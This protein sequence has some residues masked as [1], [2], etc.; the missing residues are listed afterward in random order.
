MSPD[1]PAGSSW[2]ARANLAVLTELAKL[3]PLP[4]DKH[5]LARRLWRLDEW[6]SRR[7]DRKDRNLQGE[8][9]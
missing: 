7:F 1:R 8:T 9:R 6:I 3:D 5:A 2:T 4:R